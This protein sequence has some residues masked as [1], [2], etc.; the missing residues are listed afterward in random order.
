MSSYKDPR[1]VHAD[2]RD[3]AD[4]ARR[5]ARELGAQGRALREEELAHQTTRTGPRSGFA[6]LHNLRD[7]IARLFE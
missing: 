4:A 5:V 2:V 6:I 7:E 1:P 3:L